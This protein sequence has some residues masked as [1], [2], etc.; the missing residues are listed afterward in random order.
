[1]N[2]LESDDSQARVWAVLTPQDTD[3]GQQK[4][5]DGQVEGGHD[6]SPRSR[7][8]VS[9][10]P[11]VMPRH[12]AC[13]FHPEN[14][15]HNSEG[16][17]S[18]LILKRIEWRDDSKVLSLLRLDCPHQLNAPDK[19]QQYGD[20][21]V[22]DYLGLPPNMFWTLTSLSVVNINIYLRYPIS[23]VLSPLK[24]TERQEQGTWESKD[25]NCHHL[26]LGKLV[27][28]LM[29][30]LSNNLEAWWWQWEKR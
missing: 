28:S 15:D 27:S 2:V 7:K 30:N 4:R 22:D 21:G 24:L 8:R 14:T 1:M 6:Q 23:E 10:W 20:G 12:M 19:R 18:F 17:P 13:H 3:K 25:M 9:C 26:R 11:E 16:L 5:D 29:F